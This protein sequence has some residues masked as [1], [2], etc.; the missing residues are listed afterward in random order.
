MNKWHEYTMW[1]I[2]GTKGS[3][4]I[5]FNKKCKYDPILG[6][7]NDL[8]TTDFIYKVTDEEEYEG[9]QKIVL[10]VLVNN[11]AEITQVGSIGA[12]YADKRSH[13]YFTVECSY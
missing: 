7:H 2:S 10:D 6:E 8:V 1:Y 4:K 12:I 9:F 3:A 13:G 5:W 11:T